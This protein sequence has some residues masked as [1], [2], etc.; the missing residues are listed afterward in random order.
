MQFTHTRMSVSATS[1]DPGL[2]SAVAP[3]P[4]VQTLGEQIDDGNGKP[5][6]RVDMGGHDNRGCHPTAGL[7]ETADVS[8]QV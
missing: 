1:V 7:R 2:V 6:V 3:I 4:R 5:H 8:A